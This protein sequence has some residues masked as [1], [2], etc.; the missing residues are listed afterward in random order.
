M[1]KSAAET[2]AA[3]HRGCIVVICVGVVVDARVLA[4]VPAFT[5]AVVAAP[6]KGAGDP[7]W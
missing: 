5:A 1:H 6:L 7:C 3:Q 4:A 2:A